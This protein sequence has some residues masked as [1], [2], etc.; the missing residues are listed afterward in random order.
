VT[1][2]EQALAAQ[3]AVLA[4]ALVDALPQWSVRVVTERGGR[5]LRHE[6]ERAG[7]EAAEALAPQLHALLAADVDQ[8][9]Q[10]P[11]AL[12]R[13]AVAWPTAVLREAGVPPVD[14]DDHD[15]AHFP[16]DDYGITPM[17]FADVGPSVQEA[18]ILWGAMKAH[19]HR[20]RHAS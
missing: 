1:E 17:S 11:L 9:R 2:D 19:V 13:T 3:G 4:D 12:V 5:G 16:D 18:G 6:A 8:Q 14:R 15:R 10:N 7:R 20:R